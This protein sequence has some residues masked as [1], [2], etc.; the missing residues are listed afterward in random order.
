MS[1]DGTTPTPPADPSRV[2]TTTITY[3]YD[4]AGRL[5]STTGPQ[6][7]RQYHYDEAWNLTAVTAT[8]AED[9][10]ATT[11]HQPEPPDTAPLPA[12]PAIDP[13]R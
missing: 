7:S 13:D 11:A 8:A 10:G 12:P 6:G 9:G 2:A 3:A 1:A 5:A 4:E